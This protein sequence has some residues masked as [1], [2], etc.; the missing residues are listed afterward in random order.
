M[1][2]V[3]GIDVG[4][5]GTKTLLIRRDG[6]VVGSGYQ[7]YELITD[8]GG[9]VEQDAQAWW[10]AVVFATKTA[11]KDL[12]DKSQIVA[13]SLST[14]G[15]SSLLVDKNNTPLGNSLTWMDSRAEPEKEEIAQAF[16]YD[17]IYKKT[18]WPLHS[19]LDASKLLWHKKHN[20]QAL[21]KTD[22]Y[23]STIEY[24]NT[25]MT[26]EC[27]VDPTNGAIRQLIDIE[28]SEWDKDIMA[29]LGVTESLM[30]TIKET[31]EIVGN[32]TA[33]AAQELGLRADV[34]VYNGAHDQ[35]SA[36]LGVGAIDAGDMVLSTG[37]AWVTLGITQQ[38]MFTDTRIAPAKHVVGSLW[39]A[40]TSIPVAGAALD[41]FKKIAGEDYDAINENAATRMENASDLFFYPYHIGARLPKRLKN[42]KAA[43][44]GLSLEHDKFDMYRAVMEGVVFQVKLTMDDYAA[45]G[46]SIDTLLMAGGATKSKLWMSILSAVT[47][48]TIYKSDH[49]DAACIGAAMIAAVGSGMAEDYKQAKQIFVKS[50]RIEPADKAMSDFYADKYERYLNA[51]DKMSK[52]YI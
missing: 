9:I 2:Y 29:F 52:M 48:V 50:E 44:V 17:G 40:L 8:K 36:A 33:S 15:G 10:K 11:I 39:G 51:W 46:T 5:T 13:L 38:P 22:K 26:G 16:G 43:F 24:I 28:T 1:K 21:A 14:Q 31:G 18:G 35:Y 41:W 37:T 23:V 6:E 49:P 3:L 27:I 34:V 30:P 42:A 12:P 45:N 32:L 20:A 25:K 4:T 7:G 47:G 19:T